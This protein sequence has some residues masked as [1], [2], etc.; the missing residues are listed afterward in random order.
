MSRP[1]LALALAACFASAAHAGPSN[2]PVLALWEFDGWA[3]PTPERPLGLRFVL[4]EDGSVIY[5]PDDPAIDALIPS[6]YFQAHLSPAEVWALSA[7][8]AGTLRQQ[9]DTATPSRDSGSTSFFFHDADLGALRKVSLAGHPCLA[10]GRVF[11]ATAPVAGLRAVRNSADR[12]ALS[13]AMREA[14]NRLAGFHHAGSMP[15]S[16]AS[17]PLP[18]SGGPPKE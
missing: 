13:P 17:A 2:A 14:C 8:L 9:V 5:S 1:V 18:W 11:S 7:S 16:P 10:K 12:A 6:Q 3:M 15:W 4:L